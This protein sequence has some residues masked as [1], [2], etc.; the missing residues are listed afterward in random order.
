MGKEKI[1]YASEIQQLGI[2]K[3]SLL[4]GLRS[5]SIT[6]DE[7]KQITAKRVQLPLKSALAMTIHKSQGA[8]FEYVRF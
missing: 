1:K 6:L 7:S 3:H 2:S 8:S 4:M 5:A